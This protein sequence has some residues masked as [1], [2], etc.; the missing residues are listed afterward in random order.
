MKHVMKIYALPLSLLGAYGIAPAMAA[1]D[2]AVHTEHDLQEVTI[3]ASPL[4]KDQSDIA[5]YATVLQ[6]EALKNQVRRTLGET[7]QQ[8]LGVHSSSF[9]PGVGRPVIRGQLGSRVRVQQDGND[10]LDVSAV[11][12]D[13]AVSVEPVLVDK[14]EVIRGP[15]TLVYGS[16]AIG[17][18]INVIDNRIPEQV[19]EKLQLD[20]ET[21]HGFNADETVTAGKLVG[22]SDNLAFH[23]S[24]FYRENNDLEIDGVADLEAAPGEQPSGF[25]PN[26]QARAKSGTVGFS[27]VDGDNVI[28]FA[29]N[30]LENLYGVP[31]GEEGAINLDAEQDRYDFKAQVAD[32]FKGVEEAKLRLSYND[33]EHTEIA[34]S[35][36]G[37]VFSNEAFEG[38]L[39]LTHRVKGIHGIVGVQVLDREFAAVGD[40][41]FVPRSDIT[42]QG[43]FLVQDYHADD[44]RFEWGVRVERQ[45]ISPDGQSSETH[46]PFSASAS[47][48]WSATETSDLSLVLAHSERAPAVEELFSDG[49]HEPTEAF[50]IG[51]P[52]LDEEKSMNI[53]L[54]WRYNS[55][56]VKGQVNL[57]YN[58]ISD[59]IFESEL[60]VASS[61]E[62][63][64]D[65]C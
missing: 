8:E 6:G 3:E 57:F 28:G 13:H 44:L 52:N 29:Y 38:R 56:P 64:E 46:T 37:T 48:V 31:E 11:S 50:E 59:F 33:Y 21:R 34:G 39:E 12:P 10:A 19:P 23:L 62:V 14:I 40:E 1:D 25:I 5:Q 17:G 58:N 45:R 16:G 26:T 54:S 41:A 20:V 63:I 53:E 60:T 35:E 15:N 43:L 55:G 24:G 9:G 61:D 30:R 65:C 2:K 42:S 47:V 22:G 36:A 27:W 18:V 49:L 32:P 4:H 51:D 7:L